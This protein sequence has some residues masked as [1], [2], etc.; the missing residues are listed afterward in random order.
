MLRNNSTSARKK[1]NTQICN[2]TFFSGE[3]KGIHAFFVICTLLTP[4]HTAGLHQ[5]GARE[6]SFL[7]WKA[8]AS[9]TGNLWNI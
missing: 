9:S 5:A 4:S 2:K 3:F 8:A 1:E 6:L 7:H